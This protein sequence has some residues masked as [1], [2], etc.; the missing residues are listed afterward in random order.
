MLGSI[1]G[2]VGN[3]I[4]GL[5]GESGKEKEI[6]AQK[7]F[8]KKG[9]RWRVEDAR[10][11]GVHP[12]LALGAS[13]ASFSPVGLG[14]SMAE[15]LAGASQDIGRAIDATRTV[16][17]KIDAFTQATQALTLNRM[18]LEN[19]L[20]ASQIRKLNQA[21]MPPP[22]PLASGDYNMP[23]Q[24]NSGIPA[25]VLKGFAQDA[26]DDFGDLLGDLY[27][28]G[29][30]ITSLASQITGHNP[31]THEK[32]GSPLEGETHAQ[33]LERMRTNPMY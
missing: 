25:P 11:A 10:A 20:L 22:F 7:E 3:V 9:I 19:E 21:G 2:A 23:G 12:A 28:V 1:I 13:T 14:S 8:A 16:P 17:E 29:H 27:G 24:G 26:S 33:Y 6:A 18:G 5:F 31:A 30:W 32:P 15:G 4:G